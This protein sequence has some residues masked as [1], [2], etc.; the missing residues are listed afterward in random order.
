MSQN[1]NNNNNGIGQIP[2]EQFD[3]L[4]KFEAVRLAAL[5]Q[6]DFRDTFDLK[7][8]FERAK[9]IYNEG[10]EREIDKW[11]SIWRID[12]E[13]VSKQVPIKK[14][15]NNIEPIAAISG[16]TKIC[17]NCQEVIPISWI[18]HMYTSKGGKCGHVFK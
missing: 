5:E 4:W 9:M 13:E 14:E 16:D 10:Y 6:L 12:D 8:L 15:I 11:K 17:P 1:K 3:A 7:N 2:A 18:K